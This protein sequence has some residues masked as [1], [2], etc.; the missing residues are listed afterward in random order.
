MAIKN[1]LR[2]PLLEMTNTEHREFWKILDS[3]R[4]PATK[5]EL[6]KAK[7]RR[8]IVGLFRAVKSKSA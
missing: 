2:K 7:E 6:K 8:K 1:L 4:V 3:C 5:K